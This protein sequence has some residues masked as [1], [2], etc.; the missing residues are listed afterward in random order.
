MCGRSAAAAAD[1][2]RAGADAFL[3]TGGEILRRHIEDRFAVDDFRSAGVRFDDY[4]HR[5]RFLHHGNDVSHLVRVNTAAIRANDISPGFGQHPGAFFGGVS[6][7]IPAA[8]VGGF[9]GNRSN[10]R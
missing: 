4:W 3:Y 2:F 10:N 5:G 7:D 9:E 8:P 6:H 1:E